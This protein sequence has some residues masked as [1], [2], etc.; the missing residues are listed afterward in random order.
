MIILFL[1]FIYWITS[2]IHSYKTINGSKSLLN[3]L[4]DRLYLKLANTVFT[5]I[6]SYVPIIYIWLYSRSENF[7]LYEVFD[8]ESILILFSVEKLFALMI[9]FAY[10][11]L[12][13]AGNFLAKEKWKKVILVL[14]LSILPILILVALTLKFI[15]IGNYEILIS[16]FLTWVSF[17]LIGLS[18]FF[19]QIKNGFRYP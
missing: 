10:I 13:F 14:L 16:L 1:M 12:P 7:A 15:E 8:I 9:I 11:I 18:N 19:I 2:Y 3:Y 4:Q 5:I 17:S 6:F